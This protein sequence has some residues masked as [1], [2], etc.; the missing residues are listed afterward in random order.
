MLGSR[1]QWRR[2]LTRACLECLFVLLL[3]VC[4]CQRRPSLDAVYQDAQVKFA[5][6]D[7]PGALSQ[8]E[9]GAR[10]SAET[11]VVWHWKFG[12]LRAE[13]L[14]WLGDPKQALELLKPEPPTLLSSGEFAIRRKIALG[15]ALGLM[16]EFGQAQSRLTEAKDLAEAQEPKLMADIAINLGNVFFAEGDYVGAERSFHQALNLAREYHQRLLEARS[17]VN[18]GRV[19]VKREHYDEAIDSLTES[20]GISREVGARNFEAA[21]LHN[22]GW[23]YVELGDF[24]Q[25]IPLLTDSQELSAQLGLKQYRISTLTQIGNMYMLETNYSAAEKYYSQALAAAKA[26]ND[27]TSIAVCLNN[28][29]WLALDTGNVHEAQK[30]D[31]AGL[32][33]KT[34]EKEHLSQTEALLIAADIAALQKEFQRGKALLQQVI[35]D[36]AAT[37]SN[38]WQAEAELANIYVAE[39]NP[40]VAEEQFQKVLRTLDSVRSS[41][42]HDDYKLA[43][44]SRAAEF[45]TNYIRFLIREQQPVKALQVAEFSHARTLAE[46]LGI[47]GPKHPTELQIARV[48]KFLKKHNQLILTYWLAPD[49][50]FLWAVTPS[51][52]R[53]FSLPPKHELEQNLE[54]YKR[55]LLGPNELRAADRTGEELYDLLVRP[56]ANL[57]PPGAVVI[58]IPDGGLDRLNFETLRVSSEPAHY[59]I[60]DVQIETVSSMALL[61]RSSSQLLT[62]ADRLLLIGD[63]VQTSSEYPALRHAREEMSK[64]AGYFPPSQTT[65]ISGKEATPRVYASSRPGQFGVIHFVTHGTASQT[66]PLDSAI[67]LSPERDGS[68]KLHARDVV[69]TQLHANVVIISACYGAGTRTYSGEGLVGLAWAFIRAGAHQVIAGLWEVDDVSTP[70]LMDIFYSELRKGKAAGAALRSAKLAMLNSGEVQSKPYYWASFQLYLG[71]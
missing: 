22:L 62:A 38:R 3:A 28:L 17:L 15:R 71:S 70:R 5:A 13:S 12:L 33:I 58:I 41:L 52:I 51:E 31:Q 50:S 69:K 9:R 46:G 65:V 47:Q 63:P 39:G 59:W 61:G 44:S 14:L 66:S 10:E 7:F 30:Y 4:G 32:A 23:A 26:L 56:A 6:G 57:M 24:D 68:Y 45:Y 21:A 2:R 40:R 43:F 55:V 29:A 18:L 49:S 20:L 42:A 67:I 60:E 35:S 64:V 48:Q 36:P 16:R 19:S 8:A 54:R 11:D 34:E 25:A 1:R 37:S 27:N 53:L